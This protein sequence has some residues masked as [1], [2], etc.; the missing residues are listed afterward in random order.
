MLIFILCEAMRKMSASCLF[1]NKE[2]HEPFYFQTL[3]SQYRVLRL[4]D[5]QYSYFTAFY[6]LSMWSNHDI[7][8]PLKE[9]VV[10]WCRP[11]T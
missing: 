7:I 4:K 10:G 3:I 5:T 8:E 1:A 11:T 6:R 2:N 9:T